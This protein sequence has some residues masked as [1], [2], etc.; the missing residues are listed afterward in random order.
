VENSNGGIINGDHIGFAFIAK[1]IKRDEPFGRE[2]VLSCG[3]WSRERNVEEVT[4]LH[5]QSTQ[6]KGERPSERPVQYA[7]EKDV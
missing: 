4:S 6:N 7:T 3:R 2:K 1:I 5:R